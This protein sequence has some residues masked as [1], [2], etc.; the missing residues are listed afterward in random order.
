MTLGLALALVSMALGLT[1]GLVSMT[2]GLAL[3]LVMMALILA[4]ALVSMTL[5]LALAKPPIQAACHQT[6]QAV[7]QP[8]IQAMN[9]QHYLTCHRLHYQRSQH[10][11]VLRLLRLLN[12]P[13]SQP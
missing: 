7:T 6:D 11:L 12:Q 5:G 4:L 3:D 1:L 8:R 9:Q 10:L 13:R 2:L